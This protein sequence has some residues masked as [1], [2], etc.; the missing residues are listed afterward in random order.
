MLPV[1]RAGD[2]V[3]LWSREDAVR[4]E[5]AAMAEENGGLGKTVRVRL[6]PRNTLGQQPEEQLLGVVRGPHDVEMQR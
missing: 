3:R 2:V 6:M 1:V 4:I 5:L